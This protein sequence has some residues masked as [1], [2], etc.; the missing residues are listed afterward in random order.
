M[1]DQENRELAAEPLEIMD[2]AQTFTNQSELPVPM[3]AV[4]ER[5]Y[6]LYEKL[7]EQDSEMNVVFVTDDEIHALNLEW[8]Q[9]DA[10]TDVLSFPMREGDDLADLKQLDMPLPLGD[11]AISIE[12][13]MRYVENCHHKDRINENEM[14]PLTETWCLLDEITFQIIH[15]TLHLLGYDHAE[16]EEE[17]VMRAKEKEYMMF[18]LNG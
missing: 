15:G 12:T 11:I 16:P 17:A 13:A 10:P 6:R 1:S 5:I 14:K 7:G 18:L 8:R 2:R 9:V 4:A 3:R